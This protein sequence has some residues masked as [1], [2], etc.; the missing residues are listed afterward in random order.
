MNQPRIKLKR[1]GEKGEKVA[2]IPE[3]LWKPGMHSHLLLVD[4]ENSLPKSNLISLV[5]FFFLLH[6]MTT[7]RNS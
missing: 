2:S 3:G 7:V 4:F 5:R 6:I 1:K